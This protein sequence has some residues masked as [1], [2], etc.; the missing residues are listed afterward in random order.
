M[1]PGTQLGSYEILSALGKG[2]MGEVWRAKDS[3]LGREVAIK[4]LPEEFAQ[5]E[6]RLARFERE[7]KL[8]ASL[9]HPNIAAIYG[10]EEDN[11][12]R[13]LVLELVEGDTLAERL[14]RGA[15]PVEES[16]TLALQIAEALEAAHEKGVIHR[17][18]KPLNIKITPD[19]KIKVLD[20]GLAKAFA[21]DGSDVNLSQSP[22]LSMA[23]TE[24]GVILGTAAYMSPEQARGVT[25]DKRADIWAFGCVLYEMLTGR[26]VFK[27]E[28]MSDVM[29][30]VLKSDPDYKGLP[31]AIH[32]Q[33]RAVLRRCLEKEPKQRW[34]DVGDVRV[35][36]EQVS[37]DPSGTLIV[38]P[39][40]ETLATQSKLPWVA[41]M[42][43]V[44]FIA[45]I[46]AWTL[47][48]ETE[49][50]RPVSRHRHDLP[51]GIGFR[52]P[53]VNTIAVSPDG[54]Y[55]VYN[56]TGGLYLRSR[57]ELEARVIAGTEGDV[58]NPLFSRDSEW[59]GFW[60]REGRIEKIAI[61][62]GTPIPIGPAPD[63]PNGIS[64]GA[65]DI[66]LFTQSDGIY[67]VSANGGTPEL[68]IEAR[69]GELL[70]KPTFLPSG[71]EILF[72]AAP[73]AGQWDNGE[74]VVASLDAP[75][76]RTVV[77][78]GS[79]ASYA[80][81]GH[82]IYALANDLFAI[83]F[84]PDTM[85]TSGTA[86]SL[87]QGLARAGFTVISDT[88]N[89][90]MSEDGSLVYRADRG[91]I[92]QR[93][94]VWVD[95]EGNDTPVGAPIDDYRW[96]SVSPDG[97]RVALTIYD[98]T[99]NDIYIWNFARQTPTRLTFDEA[100]DG[101]PIWTPDSQQI[102]FRSLRDGSGNIYRRRA[103]GTG[104]VEQLTEG[105]GN[106]FPQ[107][108]SS[109]G[110]TLAFSQPSGGTTGSD[111]LML[112]LGSGTSGE[113]NREPVMWLQTEFTEGNPMISPD[114][115][116]V[117][118]S[119]NESS[120]ESRGREVYVRPFADAGQWQVSRAGGNNPLW[121][122]DGQWLYYR[123]AGPIVNPQMMRVAI[124]A[125]TAF[126]FGNPE[127][128]FDYPIAGAG[129]SP[130]GRFLLIRDAEVETDPF[131]PHIITVLNWFEE[132]KERVPV[133]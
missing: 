91:A 85:E 48:P 101:S 113:A 120:N 106:R 87:E 62:G 81:T 27:G 89:Y 110:A 22:T 109:D 108:L 118:Y 105:T 86:V 112:G 129:I 52:N 34:H 131:R 60:N 42:V 28:L 132:L 61:N 76:D 93:I 111:I 12:T 66:V 10:L 104:T 56:G 83:A 115:Q 125:D 23:A 94:L 5:D 46:A 80:P 31:P 16:L 130:D 37:A 63:N 68:V 124:D 41:A 58:T 73:G 78:N 77:W 20:F 133:P 82:L 25:V 3:K 47:K 26:Q 15:I 17:D 95:A 39:V 69:D 54:Q 6:E 1:T 127:P 2:G 75:E 107:S 9:N 24:Q 40:A 4:T 74:I 30:S 90:G 126:E 67:S 11:G 71:R 45:G 70:G 51:E 65:D 21:G 55:Y 13:F 123:L 100:D 97:D 38:Q 98:G 114:G 103:D 50:P 8:L 119:S 32:P 64:W 99:Q 84:D 72:T 96:T 29:A 18:L 14:K 79:A 35:E 92:Q 121:S 122:P 59:V 19:G 49:F 102:I 116:W 33:L 117:A 88:A 57:N 44:A 36:L 7:A 128:L 43:V 53:G